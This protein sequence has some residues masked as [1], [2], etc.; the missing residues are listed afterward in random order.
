MEKRS[1]KRER[2]DFLEEM[3]LEPSKYIK[4]NNS[5]NV[6][7][8]LSRCMEKEVYSRQKEPNYYSE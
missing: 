3:T 5:S 6:K 2:S 4:T 1:P 8:E 7:M